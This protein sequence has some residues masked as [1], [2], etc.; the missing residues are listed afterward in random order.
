M[1]LGPPAP[2]PDLSYGEAIH[3]AK[4]DFERL[5]HVHAIEWDVDLDCGTASFWCRC[6]RKARNGTALTKHIIEAVAEARGP[7]TKR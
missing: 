4:Q 6:D 1:T 5:R 2:S 3:L 7:R